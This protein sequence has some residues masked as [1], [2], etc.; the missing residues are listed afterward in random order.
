MKESI[1]ILL[2]GRDVDA[3]TRRFYTD[4]K[5][6]R[7]GVIVLSTEVKYL[8][9]STGNFSRTSRAGVITGPQRTSDNV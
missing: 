1:L 9:G 7:A 3:K 4:R 6:R 5:D 8:H 2:L